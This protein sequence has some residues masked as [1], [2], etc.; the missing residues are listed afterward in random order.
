MLASLG[1]H[2]AAL[3]ALVTTWD[4]VPAMTEPPALAVEWVRLSRIAPEP[5]PSVPIAAPP[6]AAPAKIRSKPVV[7]RHPAAI[8]SSHMP[9]AETADVPPPVLSGQGSA[10]PGLDQE[11][12]SAASAPV[13]TSPGYRLGDALTPAPDYPWSARRRGVEGRVVVRLHVDAQ[14]HPQAVELLESSGDSALDR[15]AVTTLRHWR[16]YPAT[17]HGQPVD[18]QVVVP[19]LFKLT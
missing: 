2:G 19:I 4:P 11:S 5:P 6:T 9:A 3:A 13:A 7:A 14:G 8:A 18:G 15:A 1:L 16:L 12:G 10:P 17:A